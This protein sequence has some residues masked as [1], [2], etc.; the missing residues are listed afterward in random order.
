MISDILLCSEEGKNTIIKLNNEKK[1]YVV[2]E[3]LN[4]HIRVYDD[5]KYEI[6]LRDDE[7]IKNVAVYV[8]GDRKE[9]VFVNNKII[10]VDDS[11]FCFDGIIGFAQMSFHIIYTNGSDKWLYS[12]YLSVL[13]KSSS[14]NVTIDSML[15]YVYKNQIDILRSEGTITDLGDSFDKSF[16]DFWSQIV[17]IE[18]IS[19]VYESNYGYFMANCRYKLEQTEVLDRVE[20]LQYVDSK[21]IQYIVQHP[22]YLKREVTGIRYGRQTFLPSKT[23]MKTNH[24]TYDIYENQVVMSFVKLIYDE[25][26]SLKEKVEKYLS[27]I[28]I[29]PEAEDG[30]I[31][32]SQLLYL[33]AKEVLAEFLENLNELEKKYQNLV[34][35]YSRV[36]KVTIINMGRQPEPTAI[37]LNVPQ[38][39]RVYMCI[40]RWFGRVGYDL[41]NE[42]IMLDFSDI[43]TIYEA[44][45]LI[46]LINQIRDCG[47]ELKESKHVIYP[48]N[49]NW[50][51]INKR[52]NN[53]FI[54]KDDNSEVVLYYEPIIYDE[55]RS[56]VNGI[57]L[58][59]NN[60]VSINRESEE[61]M[62]GHY[63]V[64]DYI[65][66][67]VEDDKEK[68]IICD[69]KFTGKN[70]VR[71]KKIPDL[72]FK[73]LTSISTLT[74][75]AEIRGLYVFYGLNE[76]DTRG[77]SFYDRQNRSKKRIEPHIELVPLSEIISYAEQTDNAKNMLK[78]IVGIG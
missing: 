33:N 10:F 36:L 77:Q 60:S 16:D 17:L 55:D 38:Y 69:A 12:D 78:S 53:T 57:Q 41:I 44:Y 43:P 6:E 68:Y 15:K 21:T 11:A 70:T 48:R 61:E 76:E 71:Y 74:E 7:D 49:P 4:I 52:Y 51:Y 67:H 63:Y 40:R 47:Y 25:I 20:K 45:V 5:L 24:I 30:Y 73:Y 64:P 26:V 29:E 42:K 72:S 62:Q 14:T 50:K 2:E 75:K 66:K 9:S 39:N 58:Y 27:I 8:N 54:F 22:E 35:S 18:E 59:R 19:N 1:H 23:V 31:V 34:S 37:F 3:I 46:K 28:S 56:F 13:I 65:I 32:S